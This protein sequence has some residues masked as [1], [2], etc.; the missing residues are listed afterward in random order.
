MDSYGK[1][2]RKKMPTKNVFCL[3]FPFASLHDLLFVGASWAKSVLHDLSFQTLAS[4]EPDFA[5]IHGRG[6][7]I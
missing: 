5:A 7:S 4:G 3:F 1:S 2:T 6:C